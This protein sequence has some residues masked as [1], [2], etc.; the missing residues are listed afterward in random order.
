MEA[1]PIGTASERETMELDTVEPGLYVEVPSSSAHYPPPI[2]ALNYEDLLGM[3]LD[4]ECLATDGCTV[5][6][7]GECEH[8]YPSWL[9]YLGI[10]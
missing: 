1:N 9:L 6:P 10:L 2:D 4:R 7:Q 8:G 3:G 5:D